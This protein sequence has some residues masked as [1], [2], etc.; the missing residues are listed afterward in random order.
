MKECL[1]LKVL[2]ENNLNEEAQVGKV[3]SLGSKV[4]PIYIVKGDSQLHLQIMWFK[5]LQKYDLWSIF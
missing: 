3:C 1:E 5:N 4:K 2:F